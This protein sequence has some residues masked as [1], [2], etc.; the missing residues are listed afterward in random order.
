MVSWI[1]LAA[2][3]VGADE[4]KA[5]PAQA[6]GAVTLLLYEDKSWTH[7]GDGRFSPQSNAASDLTTKSQGEILKVQIA[8][9]AKFAVEIA[10]PRWKSAE[11]TGTVIGN[12]TGFFKTTPTSVELNGK[13]IGEITKSGIF[14]IRFDKK[15]LST[16]PKKPMTLTIRCGRNSADDAD[17]QELGSFRLRLSEE[18]LPTPRPSG[19]EKDQ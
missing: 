11:F 18:K 3:L 15:L 4:P 2:A 5:K 7:I 10:K 8:V 1:V 16:D 14:R 12:D 19:K 6:A 13:K 9:A 17:D